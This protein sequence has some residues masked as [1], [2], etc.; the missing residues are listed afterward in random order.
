MT[1]DPKYPSELAERFQ[2]RLPEGMRDLMRAAAA[3]SGR[4]MNAEIVYRLQWSIDEDEARDRANRHYNMLERVA[5]GTIDPA[6]IADVGDES[7][8]PAPEYIPTVYDQITGQLAELSQQQA[9]LTDR[10]SVVQQ[11]LQQLLQ[12]KA[13]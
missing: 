12:G 6:D 13:T 1:Q 9:A 10:V 2:V 8:A 4:S 3:K 5:D 11:T 7:G